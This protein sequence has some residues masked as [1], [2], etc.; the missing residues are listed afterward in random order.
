LHPPPDR[1]PPDLWP[2]LADASISIT[3]FHTFLLRDAKEIRGVAGNTR[4]L[5]IAGRAVVRFRGTAER[6][7]GFLGLRATSRKTGIKAIYDLSATPF[8]LG[9]SGYQEGYIFPWVASDF[10]LMDSIEPGIVK[11]PRGPGDDECADAHP[12]PRTL[13]DHGGD[14]LPKR[15]NRKAASDSEWIPPVVLQGALESLY[16]SYE[17]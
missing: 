5:L 17:R 11:V 16:H 3:N 6:R 1:A 10:S 2:P 13:G 14:Q 15:A 8:Y 9:G 12:T 7:V 4:K